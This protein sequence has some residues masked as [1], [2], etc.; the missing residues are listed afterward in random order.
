MIIIIIRFKTKSEKREHLLTQKRNG[1][2]I[3]IEIMINNNDPFISRLG[4]VSTKK[5]TMKYN[6]NDIVIVFKSLLKI[7]CNEN[8]ENGNN[9]KGLDKDEDL[10]GM[11]TR[12]IWIKKKR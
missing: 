12:R 10:E 4:K 3:V 11:I 1:L 6:D 9:E 8:N 2:E 7:Q 5:M